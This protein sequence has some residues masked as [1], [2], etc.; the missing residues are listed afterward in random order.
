MERKSWRSKIQ[1][2]LVISLVVLITFFVFTDRDGSAS[3]PHSGSQALKR[4]E[5]GFTSMVT[6]FSDGARD[7]NRNMQ[8]VH[9]DYETRTDERVRE[10]SGE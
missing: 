7:K 2:G 10:N 9:D 6:W 5:R 8:R 1:T 3:A 4:V